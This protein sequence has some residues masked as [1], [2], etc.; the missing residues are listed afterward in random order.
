MQISPLSTTI[1][2]ASCEPWYLMYGISSK[3]SKVHVSVIVLF[4]VDH[5]GFQGVKIAFFPFRQNYI[6]MN[7]KASTVCPFLHLG[8]SYH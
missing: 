1:K 7:F 2:A 6:V 3:L 4:Y 5:K 8:L